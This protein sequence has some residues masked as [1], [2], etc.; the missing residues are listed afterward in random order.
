L[1]AN[2]DS[3]H[4]S[5]RE[6][7]TAELQSLRDADETRTILR[8]ALAHKPSP[9]ASRRIDRLLSSPDILLPGDLLRAVRAIEILERIGTAE[10]Q[11]LLRSLAE[12][13][14]DSRLTRETIASLQRLDRKLTSP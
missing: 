6:A 1:L 4:Y 9:E 11:R 13:A 2:L 12:G 8:R 3:D 14:R 7:A 10:A 5:L